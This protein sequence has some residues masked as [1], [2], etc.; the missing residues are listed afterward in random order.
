MFNITHIP[1]SDILVEDRA[2]EVYGDLDDL[3]AD[4][5]RLGLLYPILVNEKNRLLDGG[6]RLI[7]HQRLQLPTI[8]C[9]VLP[10]LEP[11]DFIMIEWIGNKRKDFEWHEE[12]LLKSRLHQ[13]WISKNPQWGYRESSKKMGIS[14]GG[15][16]TDLA[17]AVAIESFPDLKTQ[18]TKGKAREAY[19]KLQ[20]SAQ[21]ITAVANLPQVEQDR[22]NAMLSGVA[23]VDQPVLSE[24]EE[25]DEALADPAVLAAL[26][27]GLKSGITVAENRPSTLPE[28]SYEIC[29]YTELLAK[30]PDGIVGF[31]ELDPPYAIDFNEIYGKSQDIQND[32]QDWTVEKLHSAMEEILPALYAKMLD[33]SW[34][35]IWTGHEH[36]AWQNELAKQVGF[37]IQ[38]PGIWKKPSGGSNTPSTTMISNYE[39]FLLLRKGNAVFNTPS[40]NAAIDCDTVPSSKRYHMWEKPMDIY[41][42]FF[43]AMGKPGAIFLS[44]F[45]GSGNSMITA[46]LY[47]M[48]PM[49]CDIQQKHFYH[50]YTNFKNHHL[51]E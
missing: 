3:Q 30:L 48:K 34:V 50:F 44:L 23:H 20:S 41:R 27:Q 25:I 31:C 21:A 39:T 17:L 1:V 15:L 26:A 37:A 14:L 43:K 7:V 4:I 2:R 46:S 47:N 28:F 32:E 29:T 16:S 9:R 33:R 42:Q 36:A 38:K 10:G 24:D 8:A 19:K 13:Y 35:L 40:L 49:G 45:A 5:E 12:L 11:D 22:I 18:A 51:E 6:R